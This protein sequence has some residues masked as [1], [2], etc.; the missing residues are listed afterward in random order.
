[1]VLV[2]GEDIKMVCPNGVAGSIPARALVVKQRERVTK[3]NLPQCPLPVE[4]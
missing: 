1:L 2:S 3:L 4:P